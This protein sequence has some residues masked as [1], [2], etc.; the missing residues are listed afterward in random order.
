MEGIDFGDEASDTTTTPI[1]YFGPSVL[2]IAVAVF[3]IVGIIVSYVPQY[4]AII[5]RKS[6]EGLSVYM[7]AFSLLSS[8]LTTVNSGILKWPSVICCGSLGF[9]HCMLNNLST[10]QLIT[11]LISLIIFFL[12]FLA[13]FPTQPT[14]TQSRTDRIRL[15]RLAWIIFIVCI[16]CGVFSS[17]LG[18]VLY[19]KFNLSGT[20]LEQYAAGLGWISAACI[21]VQ[22]SPQIF[23]TLRMKSAGSLSV[24]MLVLQMPG[25][26]LIIF[27][28]GVLNGASYTTWA[29]Y[30]FQAVQQLI[31]III[32]IVFYIR[33]RKKSKQTIVAIPTNEET[34]DEGQRLLSMKYGTK[35][36]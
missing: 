9:G 4:V 11:G 32:C 14:E 23:T 15:K 7:I 18:G 33:D 16:I 17:V 8:F 28:Q 12:I 26:L 3:L 30:V 36:A 27:F 20:I 29:P 31:L 5:K 6:S 2:N 19:Y 25:A 10:E 24:L 1:C 13:Y 21:V 35:T 22:Y 34:P